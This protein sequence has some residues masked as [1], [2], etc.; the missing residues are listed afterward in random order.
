MA[1]QGSIVAKDPQRTEDISVR[2]QTI[3]W[4]ASTFVTTW[5]LGTGSDPTES[6]ATVVP[7]PNSSSTNNENV[8]PI[9][10]GVVV[11][12]V[13]I[14]ISWFCCRQGG[15]N[16]RNSK[17]SSRRQGSSYTSKGSSSSSGASNASSQ[18]DASVGS[19]A[20]EIVEDQWNQA[21]PV[22]ERPIPG[23]PPPVAGQ[24]PAQ[25]PG[26]GMGQMPLPPHPGM[27]FSPGRGG[28]PPMMGQGL[29]GR[30]GPPPITGRGGFPP[31]KG[32]A[33]HKVL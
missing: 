32:V 3:I 6:P 22:P 23:M 21:A 19:A 33:V 17:R 15:P 20:S 8:G 12:V 10:S 27:S 11:L 16:G 18:N 30:G 25:Q 24:W 14:L 5:T 29:P 13:L 31:G 26:V 1:N 2:T 4:P 7:A 28:P 9:L